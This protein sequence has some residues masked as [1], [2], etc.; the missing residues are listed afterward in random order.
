M[1]NTL[2]QLVDT[3]I[4]K[5][6]GIAFQEFIDSLYLLIHGD[7]FTP[8]KQKHDKGCDGIIDNHTIIACYAPER[9]EFE[10]FKKKIASNKKGKEGDFIKYQANWAATHPNFTII[11][12]GEWLGNM[13]QLVISLKHDTKCIG[14]KNLIEKIDALTWT[15]QKKIFDILRIDETYI[16]I[17]HIEEVVKDLK[18][19]L[20]TTDNI[21]GK[22]IIKG[23][24]TPLKDKIHLNYLQNELEDAMVTFENYLQYADKI[25]K[26]LGDFEELPALKLKVQR[27]YIVLDKSLSFKQRLTFL[28]EQNAQKRKDDATYCYYLELIFL[29][30][31]EQCLIG[32][33]L[34][35]Q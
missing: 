3:Q 8:I 2:T 28:I 7:N 11:I 16:R 14:R 10:D 21:S 4:S 31:F 30:I 29:Y 23:L 33:K 1:D 26:I 27:E 5:L 25:T 13:K 6:H 17:S 24:S 19:T 15:K 9:V 12:N 22:D 20:D 32:E 18:K 35:N 34:P